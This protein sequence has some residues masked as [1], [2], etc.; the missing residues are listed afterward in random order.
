MFRPVALPCDELLKGSLVCVVIQPVRCAVYIGN[1]K[2]HRT[3]G[4]FIP[5]RLCKTSLSQ[6][7][8]RLKP[9]FV[10]KSHILQDLDK[11]RR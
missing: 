9:V 7:P 4:R 1:S 3:A 5:V 6:Q 11:I 10:I 2:A 8:R